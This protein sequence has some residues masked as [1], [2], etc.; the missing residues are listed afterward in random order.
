MDTDM[1]EWGRALRRHGP[2]DPIGHV[3]SD[4]VRALQ[5]QRRA[6]AKRARE[7]DFH[8]L[9]GRADG[10]DML[11]EAWHRV[12]CNKGPA[13]VDRLTIDEVEQD[14][15][16]RLLQEP[17]DVLRAGE[18]GGRAVR[19]V[20]IPEADGAK[21]SQ[22]SPRCATGW[23]RWPQCRYLSQSLRRTSCRL[24]AG[25]IPGPGAARRWCWSGS[26]R[27]T[28]VGADVARRLKGIRRMRVGHNPRSG[29]ARKW[30]RDCLED[31][32]LHPLSGTTGCKGPAFGIQQS[33]QRSTTADH[34][35]AMC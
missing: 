13:G 34:W 2:A 35:S 15:V 1:A 3:S 33:E 28:S 8:A 19:R 11:H 16:E 23:C 22:A 5:R 17:A 10:A 32:G 14:G 31:G 30:D 6:A 21:S 12:R 25:S 27:W 4:E 18:Y 9:H 7:R 20:Y 26:G 24:L 29:R